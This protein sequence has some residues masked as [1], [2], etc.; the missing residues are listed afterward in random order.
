MSKILK[1]NTASDVIISDTGQTVPA[2]GQLTIQTGDYLL[3]AGSDDVVTL[4]GNSTLTVNDGSDDL[5]INDGI[6][7]IQ[8]IFPNPVGANIL[9]NDTDFSTETKQ[10]NLITQQTSTNTKLDTLNSKDFA[11]S[12]KQDTSN[13]SLNSIDTKLTDNA[14]A[15]NQVTLNTRVGDLTETAPASDTASSGLNGRLQRIAQRISSLIT[16]MTTGTGILSTIRGATDG[17]QIGNIA[18]RLKVV[19]SPLDPGE[20]VTY[21]SDT[22]VVL[23]SDVT[24]TTLH[25][26]SGSGVFVGA[27]FVVDNDQAECVIEIDGNVVFDFTGAFLSEVVNKDADYKASG[28][29]GV[30]GDGKRLYCTPITPFNYETSLVFKARKS[31]K[32]VKYQLYTYSEM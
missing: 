27:S 9:T 32:K 15:T 24:Y 1:N 3:Y 30:T 10:D 5:S 21:K 31:G 28:L 14:T 12:A 16:A 20:F 7:L 13:T 2:S 22:E 4:V 29:F 11:T 6:K 18:D 19:S 17:T 26:V 25:S 8:G 23:S